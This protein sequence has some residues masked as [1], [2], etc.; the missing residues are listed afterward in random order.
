VNWTAR[1]GDAVTKGTRFGT[2]VGSTRSLLVAERLVLNLMQRMSGIATASALYVRTMNAPHTRLL[3]TRKTVPG[4]RLLDK[5][6]VR[7]GGGVN[8]RVGLYDMVLIKVTSNHTLLAHLSWPTQRTGLTS[9]LCSV[10][11]ALRT[12]TSKRLVAFPTL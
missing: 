10:L 1:D 4:L 7:H 11:L 12:T 9:L 5:L 8:H 3:D 6:A 2:V